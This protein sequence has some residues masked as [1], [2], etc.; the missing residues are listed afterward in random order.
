M[1]FIIILQE[2]THLQKMI[3]KILKKKM[4]KHLVGAVNIIVMEMIETLFLP[5]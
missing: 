5:T 4:E 2:K 3:L 1:D